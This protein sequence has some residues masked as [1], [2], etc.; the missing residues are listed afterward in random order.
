M[1]DCIQPD[2]P[3][4]LGT[5]N[6][7]PQTVGRDV[8]TASGQ[9]VGRIVIVVDSVSPDHPP[10]SV[11]YEDRDP[12]TSEVRNRFLCRFAECTGVSWG[13]RRRPSPP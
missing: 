8:V 7:Q 1:G 6:G 13:A 2:D 3:F 9:N 4:Q 12:D 5:S 11:Y 10:V